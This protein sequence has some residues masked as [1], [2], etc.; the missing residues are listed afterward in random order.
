MGK[1]MDRVRGSGMQGVRVGKEGG[2]TKW[3]YHMKFK[4]SNLS[5]NVS[6]LDRKREM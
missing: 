1:K 2:Y 3:V 5:L 4:S 6:T